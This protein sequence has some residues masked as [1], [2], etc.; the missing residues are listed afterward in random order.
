MS[1]P[2]IK[3]SKKGIRELMR[4]AEVADEVQKV[5][6]EVARAAGPEFEARRWMRK[7]KAVSNVVDPRDG[8]LQREA[9]QGNLARAV[10][11]AR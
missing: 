5:A 10:G 4:T 8:A 6:E 2:R 3:L 11:R 1:K 9:A 7:T